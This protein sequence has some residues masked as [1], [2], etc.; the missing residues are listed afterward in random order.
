[1]ARSQDDQS[2]RFAAYEASYAHVLKT[3]VTNKVIRRS[4]M[5][6]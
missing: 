1:M 2:L 5:S 3:S 4:M 6:K